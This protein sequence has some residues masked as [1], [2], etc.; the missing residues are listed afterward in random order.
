MHVKP[1]KPQTMK[2]KLILLSTVWLLSASPHFNA[3]MSE[4]WNIT[5]DKNGIQIYTR[6]I[7]TSPNE[8]TRQVK[9]IVTLRAAR[10]QIAGLITNENQARE[11]M[12]FLD[13]LSYYKNN[14]NPAEWYAYGRINAL[15][16]LVC[17]DVVTNNHIL[18]DTMENQ[19]VIT[20]NGMPGYLPLKTGVHRI[21]G[22]YST[23]SLTDVSP[24]MTRIEFTI[25]SD[26]KPVVPTWITDPFV[27]RLLISTLEK[28]RDH[29]GEY[30]LK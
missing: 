10:E 19:T 27:A 28:L 16:K 23:W 26:M 7:R 30:T 20:M 8:K 6:W 5:K 25:Q 1:I 4:S 18:T 12:V 29:A 14:H 24:E 11:W 21:T 9:G 17:F 13:E 15:G 3:E 2:T 22:L